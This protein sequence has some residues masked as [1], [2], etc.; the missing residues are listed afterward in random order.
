MQIGIK[1]KN[2]GRDWNSFRHNAETNQPSYWMSTGALSPGEKWL[3]S[4]AVTELHL[5]PRFFW[6]GVFYAAVSS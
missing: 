5:M 6:A 1:E 2:P 4:K 3:E